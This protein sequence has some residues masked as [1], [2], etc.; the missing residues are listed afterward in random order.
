M[1][2]FAFSYSMQLSL[3]A[4]VTR[5]SYALRC[6][7]PDTARQTVSGLQY[8][9]LGDDRPSRSVD[10]FGSPLLTGYI[11]RPH[12]FFGFS[13]SGTAVLRPDVFSES[14]DAALYRFASR[15]TQ[16][17]P[18]LTALHD[19]LSSLPGDG[20]GFVPDDSPAARAFAMMHAVYARMRYEPGATTVSTTAEQA[21]SGG[22]GVCQDYVHLL[23]AL[24]RMERIP[25][26]YVAGLLG[27]E[28]A[29]HAWCEVWHGGVWYPI[30]PTHDC[31]ALIGYLEL[32]H[33]RDAA[34]CP[35]DRGV[36]YGAAGQTQTVA[37]SLSRLPESI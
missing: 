17:G 33:G 23:L 21:L 14:G 4:P 3:T 8:T 34:D 5:H 24:C 36:W 6:L 26:R 15:L 25:A 29:T 20:M 10:G 28:G 30:D 19:I 13:V 27:G 11:A 9:V 18:A 7:P 31:P 1:P 32:A 16:P 22:A 12:D 35:L 37:A 2:L